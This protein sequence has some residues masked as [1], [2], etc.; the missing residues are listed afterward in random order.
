MVPFILLGALVVL[1]L[2][3]AIVGVRGAPGAPPTTISTTST[4]P[5]ASTTS[6]TTTSA[7][8]PCGVVPS[9][10]V[11]IT[12]NTFLCSVTTRVG[13]TI[14]VVLNPGLRWSTPMSD[15]S[16]LVVENVQRQSP[17]GLDADLIAVR[18]G[19]AS[20]TAMGT[21]LCPPGARAR[22]SSCSGGC[23]S[24]SG[25][26]RGAGGSA[27][28]TWQVVLAHV[29]THEVGATPSGRLGLR[30]DFA[31]TSEMS[32]VPTLATVG[33]PRSVGR[34]VSRRSGGRGQSQAL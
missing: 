4:P 7:S 32:G 12:S 1:S 5:S 10:E 13:D 30:Y 22:S 14:H 26:R 18:A 9:P 21:A 11:V 15:S 29:P 27:P 23:T 28:S 20:V 33:T 17:G 31:G 3:A 19:Q 24:P 25:R 2:G 16:V 6:T 34:I 8:Y